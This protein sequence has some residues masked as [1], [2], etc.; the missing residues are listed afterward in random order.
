MK[1]QSRLGRNLLRNT[2][3]RKREAKFEDQVNHQD[4]IQKR[5]DRVQMEDLA[6]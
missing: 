4:Q 3:E 2:A 1:I 5:I 6:G